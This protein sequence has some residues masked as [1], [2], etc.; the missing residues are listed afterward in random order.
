MYDLNL[1]TV[2]WQE[3]YERAC[4]HMA[5]LVPGWSDEIPSDPAVALLELTS[6]LSAVQNREINRLQER[7]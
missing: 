6:C 3:L 1:D 5:R 4:R 7:H 2:R